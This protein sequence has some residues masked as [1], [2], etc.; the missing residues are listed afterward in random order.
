MRQAARAKAQRAGQWL[1]G[2]TFHQKPPA[3]VR[4]AWLL[5]CRCAVP[6]RP[7]PPSDSGRQYLAEGAAAAAEAA[8]GGANKEHARS[9]GGERD[10][11]VGIDASQPERQMGAPA[12][13]LPRS[14]L[15]VLD[16]VAEQEV[17]SRARHVL[18]E[19]PHRLDLG[20]VGR[21]DKV[22]LEARPRPRLGRHGKGGRGACK[23]GCL[24]R[25][26]RRCGVTRLRILIMR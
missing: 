18:V 5:E 13:S 3:V 16:A 2:P 19:A 7:S 14:V 24:D 8:A 6:S 20:L 15:N 10:T 23:H 26:L 21:E 9:T 12:R 22:H 4:S 17:L 25:L 11:A 1:D